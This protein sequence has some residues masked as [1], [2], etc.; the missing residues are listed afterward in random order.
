MSARNDGWQDFGDWVSK[1]Q[2]GE[3]VKRYLV[4][5][6][7]ATSGWEAITHLSATKDKFTSIPVTD[8]AHE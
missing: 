6:T 3:T 7:R 8:R 4:L 5:Y 1:F 2:K